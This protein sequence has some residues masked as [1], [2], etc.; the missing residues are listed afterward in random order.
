MATTAGLAPLA[1]L[2]LALVLVRCAVALLL[3]RPPLL[4]LEMP[5][6]NAVLPLYL[7]LRLCGGFGL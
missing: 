3:P 1:L 7:L 5:R 4:P 2:A 6:Q